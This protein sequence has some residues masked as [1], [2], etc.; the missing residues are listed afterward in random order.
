[1]VIW[2]KI[3]YESLKGILELEK[4]IVDGSFNVGSMPFRNTDQ[5]K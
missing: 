5:K 1:C 2:D 4:A 3:D